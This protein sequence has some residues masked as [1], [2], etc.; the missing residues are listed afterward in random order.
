MA[1]ILAAKYH[2]SLRKLVVWGSNAYFTEKDSDL[3]ESKLIIWYD[4]VHPSLYFKEQ[5]HH[6][7]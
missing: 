1:T 6:L 7:M 4:L 3:F 2:D 5:L